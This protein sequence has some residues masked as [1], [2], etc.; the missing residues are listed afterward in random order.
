MKKR[1][2][3][4][5]PKGF[6]LIEL[7]VVVLIIGILAAVA[8]PQYQKA[9]AKTKAVQGLATLNALV[10]AEEAYYLANGEYAAEDELDKLDISIP[11]TKDWT[12]FSSKVNVPKNSRAQ[13][14]VTDADE[15]SPVFFVYYLATKQKVCSFTKGEDQKKNICLL[16]PHIKADCPDPSDKGAYE[17]YYM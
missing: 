15:E 5:L 9:V 12:V 13:F 14:Y 3:R 2:Q 16:L 4:R 11:N 1:N 10:Q 8:L 7:L 17:C 6:T